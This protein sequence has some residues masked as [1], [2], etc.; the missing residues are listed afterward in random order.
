MGSNWYLDLTSGS[1]NY[2]GRLVNLMV[3]PLVLPLH[4]DP[5]EQ[6]VYLE[7]CL[8]DTS[9]LLQSMLHLN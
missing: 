8:N 5:L 2:I 1:D 9:L 3:P 4:R 7:H 6:H